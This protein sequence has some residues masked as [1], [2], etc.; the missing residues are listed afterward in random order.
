M[1]FLGRQSLVRKLTVSMALVSGTTLL[2]ASFAWLKYDA[3]KFKAS[4]VDDLSILSEIIGANNT[5]G[6]AFGDVAAVEENLAALAFREEIRGAYVY[7]GGDELFAAY[8]RATDSKVP[9][10]E[11]RAVGHYYVGDDLLVYR[12][13][14]LEGE[15]I[16]TACIQLDTAFIESRERLLSRIMAIFF[17]VSCGIALALSYALQRLISGPILHLTATVKRV[18]KNKDYSVRARKRSDDEL[19]ILTDSFNDMLGKIQDRDAELER[20]RSTLEQEVAKRTSA[21][22]RAMEETRKATAAKS[23]F[24]AKMSHEIRTPMN[25]VLGMTELLMD[26]DLDEV[27]RDYAAIAKGSA[28]SL[29][30][31]INDIL[32]ISKIE[33]GKVQLESIDFDP[34]LVAEEV[35]VLLGPQA[36]KKDLALVT[37]I[38]PAVPASM[39]GDPAR[40]RQVIT[41]LL[42]NAMKFTEDGMVEVRLDMVATPDD[43]D[44]VRFSIRDSGIGIAAESLENLFESFAQADSSTTRK[45]GGTGLGLSISKQLVELMGGE[46]G[47][48]S[49]LGEGTTFWFTLPLPPSADES[50]TRMIPFAGTKR[51]LLWHPNE[52][53]TRVLGELLDAWGLE[54]ETLARFEDLENA[55]RRARADGRAVDLV[56]L[57]RDEPCPG[58]PGSPAQ[59]LVCREATC[60]T[61]DGPSD[62]AV[63]R[64][65]EPVMPSKL[66]TAVQALVGSGGSA[67]AP[68]PDPPPALPSK[69]LATPPDFRVLLAEDNRVNQLVATRMLTKAGL[70]CDVVENGALALEAVQTGRYGLV[71]MDCQMPVMGGLE[72]TRRIREWE[73]ASEDAPARRLPIVAL[74]ANALQEEL[75]A[76][77]DAGMD[78]CLVKPVKSQLLIETI[79]EI[80]ASTDEANAA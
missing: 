62:G 66:L 47:V 30:A 51:T 24:L 41:N 32:D 43:K 58:L 31:I 33:A 27:Q 19:G 26:T 10:P 18:S 67:M 17:L 48:T 42:G 46:I 4:V 8:R 56:V 13:I 11:C 75:D 7:T 73:A 9:A 15:P 80:L 16:G 57:G 53:V 36:R 1:T 39:V 69:Q 64:V 2:V 55:L 44:R 68:E 63:H 76:C 52:D 34:A 50:T 12:T 37:M 3:V 29:L 5:A 60:P 71:L 28:E 21:L 20:H 40:I 45:Y 65:V 23:E 79:R 35:V 14:Q 49:E 72:A 77:I 59:L 22:T 61:D 25:G 78:R 38:D 6:I 74:T 54:N 70:E